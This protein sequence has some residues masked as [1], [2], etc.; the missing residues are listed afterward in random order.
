MVR[1]WAPMA[2]RANS[3]SGKL[4]PGSPLALEGM[5][6][7]ARLVAGIVCLS[8]ALADPLKGA[9]IAHVLGNTED[10]GLNL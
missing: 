5:P 7:T 4:V 2:C 9:I 1:V 6:P 8:P 10:A 3:Q